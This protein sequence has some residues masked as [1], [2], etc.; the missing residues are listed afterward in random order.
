MQKRVGIVSQ[1]RTTSSRLPGK[2]LLCAGEKTVLEHHFDR[3]KSSGHPVI[4]AT[5]TKRSDDVLCSLAKANA[6]AF[7]RADENDVLSRYAEAKKDFNLDVLVRV[8]SDCPLIDGKLIAEGIR[9]YLELDNPWIYLSNMIE[10]TYPRGF[11]FEIFSS[12]LLDY[13]LAGKL[14]NEDKEHVTLFIRKN[15]EKKVLIQHLLNT[16]DESKFRITLDTADDWSLIKTLIVNYSAQ[17]MGSNMI[18]EL[19]KDNPDLAKINQHI[20]QKKVGDSSY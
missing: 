20:E 6:V 1:A 2:I 14:E 19:L 15:K 5:S 17:N 18:I 10:R 7:V 3:L 12:K 9:K 13:T 4:L 16:T 11:D 8:T